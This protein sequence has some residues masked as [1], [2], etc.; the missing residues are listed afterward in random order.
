MSRTTYGKTG[1]GHLLNVYSRQFVGVRITLALCLRT[2]L[3][4]F[5]LSVNAQNIALTKISSSSSNESSSFIASMA[6]DGKQSTRWSSAF[7]DNQWLKIDLGDTYTLTE[8]KIMWEAAY[9]S[10]YK[11]QLSY[12]GTQWSDAYSTTTG[13]GG[14]D[15]LKIIG[16][17]RYVRVLCISR[18]TKWG[19]SIYELA[20]FGSKNQIL[21]AG[22]ESGNLTSWNHWEQKPS[23]TSSDKNTGTYSLSASGPSYIYQVVAGL[24]PNTTYQFAGSGKTASGTMYIGVKNF[25]G[26]EVAEA[27]KSSS[28][29]RSP[30]ISFT[31]SAQAT[32]A[33]IYAWYGAGVSGR[34]DDFS[35]LEDTGSTTPPPPPPTPSFTETLGKS[36]MGYNGGFYSSY[37]WP[38]ENKVFKEGVN[39]ST[40]LQQGTNVWGQKFLDDN[41]MFKMLRT[42]DFVKANYSRL[43]DWSDRT[44]PKADQLASGGTQGEPG[45]GMAYEWIINLCNRQNQYLWINIPHQTI[46]AGDK[47]RVG[48]EYNYKLAILLKHGVDMGTVTLRT[49]FGEDLAV[50]KNKSKQDFLN[51]GGTISGEALNKD[52]AIFLEYS[53]EMH[54]SWWDAFPEKDRSQFDYGR[55]QG[56]AL[57]FKDATYGSSWP[58][59][60]AYE[61]AILYQAWASVRM[62]K[63]FHDVFGDDQRIKR[64]VLGSQ[65]YFPTTIGDDQFDKVIDDSAKNP[66]KIKPD[67]YGLQGYFGAGLDGASPSFW[68][69]IYTYLEYTKNDL[70]RWNNNLKNK[71]NLK[72]IMYEGAH[73]V[74]N[75]AASFRTSPKN[76]KLYT[77]WANAMKTYFPDYMT[78]FGGVGDCGYNNGAYCWELK[79]YW[80]EDIN[81]Q[82]SYRYKALS[83]WIKANNAINNQA[84]KANLLSDDTNA[85]NSILVY[86]NP[87]SDES[88]TIQLGD[89]QAFMGPVDVEILDFNGRV[90]TTY[91]E[92]VNLR[93]S[94]TVPV[95]LSAG[96]Y[97]IRLTVNGKTFRKKI[98]IEE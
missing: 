43:K 15:I 56:K 74:V 52:L 9:A 23:V 66:W 8:V 1:C 36:M 86:P 51:T 48:N 81:S 65:A 45:D 24:K 37:A 93:N 83:D 79:Q 68:T 29:A 76:Y 16:K 97:M 46:D 98:V 33:E 77:D 61:S 88:F 6:V 20:V 67:Y 69:D 92:N 50:L 54:G 10:S 27:I 19:N 28:W 35:L 70:A 4:L 53:N 55:S 60:D 31:T 85:F 7:K 84:L 82:Y 13:D 30:N 12:N 2:L 41:K 22:F 3:F 57:G 80:G 34:S 75:N 78:S 71:H 18:A 59:N 40:A 58:L 47:N 11:F 25:G 17:A 89:A 44:K 95:N 90:M 63:V 62:W 42:L 96:I 14:T 39:W 49:I 72:M 26:P 73:H 94:L 64:L 38:N 91:H 5:A 21:N 87:V 32:S